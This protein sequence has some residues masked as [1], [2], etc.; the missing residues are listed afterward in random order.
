MD[1]VAKRINHGK[2]GA[3]TQEGDEPN[4]YFSDSLY[5]PNTPIKI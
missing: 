1:G 5:R 4:A 2:H 3:L